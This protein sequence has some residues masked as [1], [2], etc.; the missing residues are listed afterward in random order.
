MQNTTRFKIV[1]GKPFNAIFV[2][3]QP[4]SPLPIELDLA[5]V[6]TF[7]MSTFAL[8]PEVIHMNIPL[9]LGTDEDRANGKMYFS[10]TAEQTD[11]L[12]TDVAFGEDGFPLHPTLKALIEV[13]TSELGTIF[14]SVP[15]IYVENMGI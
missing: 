13:N 11:I 4:G 10:M 12:P 7:T 9:S 8:K 3:K 15:K 1:K 14:A 2:I 6:S 5:T